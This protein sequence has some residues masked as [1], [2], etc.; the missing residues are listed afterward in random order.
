MQIE[1]DQINGVE[2]FR[3]EG[4]LAQADTKIAK[5]QIS[6]IVNDTQTSR[7]LINLE[8]VPFMDSSGIGIIVSWFNVLKNRG[9]RL[10]LSDLG[11][12]LQEIMKTTRLDSVFS[13][14]KTESEA[15]EQIRSQ[16]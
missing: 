15:L 2:V 5:E 6:P 7:V 4:T 1:H 3:L 14:Y 13:I 12:N 9:G 10:A 11:H 16:S 8:N